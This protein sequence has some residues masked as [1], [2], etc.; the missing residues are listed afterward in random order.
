M[1]ALRPYPY[2][3]DALDALAASIGRGVRRPVVVL[4]TGGGKTVCF[5]HGALEWLDEH[6]EDRVVVLVHTDELVSQ[7][8]N[9]LIKVAPH[10]KVGIVKAGRNDVDAD[11]I[12][13]SVQTLRNPKRRNAIKRVSL[14][15]VDE[16]HHAAAQT[17]LDIIGHFNAVTIGYTATLVRGDGKALSAVWDEVVFQRDIGW[18][19]R[20]RYLVPPRGLAVEVPDL[21]LRAVKATRTDYR[22]GE[23]GEALAESLAP[24]LVAKAILEHAAG[25]KVLGFAPSVASAYVFAEACEELGISADVVH[26]GMPLGDE[27]NPAPGTRRYVLAQHRSGVFRVLWNCMLLTEGYDDPS[28]DCIAMA[29]PTKNRG[30]YIQIVGR[31]LRVDP[32]R[33]YEEQDCL[34]LDV[35]GA[36]AI[37]DLRSLADLSDRPI[38]PEKARSGRTLVELEDDLDAGEGVA[39]DQAELYY[40]PVQSREF[41]PLGRPSTKV[42]LKTKGGT[43]FLPAGKEQF[44]F[45]MEYPEP[46]MWSVCVTGKD[47]S[48]RFKLDEDGAVQRVQAP[49]GRPVVMTEHRGLP[50]DQALVWAGDLAQDLGADLNATNKTAPWRKKIASEKTQDLARG[51]GIEPR[52][53]SDLSG[54]FVCDE[55]AGDLS[56]RITVVMGTRRIDPQVKAVTKRG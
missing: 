42:W 47:G 26:G 43:F 18:M 49:A 3:R 5:A 29:R 37:H 44:V 16:C 23:L 13:A 1:R 39:P 8:Y 6:P 17:Y 12:V 33:P 27:R 19:V 41:D 34:I 51:L 28:V 52:G 46:G 53:H 2:Q 48:D 40:G 32:A 45:I 14:V 11:V 10:L 31:G 15:I 55:R 4:P 7:A 36:N 20:K 54:L 24:E 35:V 9:K 38:S 50:L 21:D 30:L 25:R 56:D 22:D